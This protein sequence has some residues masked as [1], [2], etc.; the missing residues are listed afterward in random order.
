MSS[1][2]PPRTGSTFANLRQLRGGEEFSD[3][4]LH[5]MNG[6]ITATG[7]TFT[8][9]AGNPAASGDFA[10]LTLP[11]LRQLAD[12]EFM[13]NLQVVATGAWNP[14]VGVPAATILGPGPVSITLPA[15]PAATVSGAALALVLKPALKGE[16]LA[17]ASFPELL[18]LLG[19]DCLRNDLADGT[20]S[21]L[22]FR[23]RYAAT[24]LLVDVV[25]DL[26]SAIVQPLKYKLDVPRPRTFWTPPF[27]PVITQP[28]H[29]SYP[30][31]HATVAHTLA[32]VMT[33]V[34]G[35]PAPPATNALHALADH[36]ALRREDAGVHTSVDSS[37]G[38]TLG[39]ALGGFM[40][41]AAGGTGF[42]VWSAILARARTEL[43]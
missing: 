16:M 39:T 3:L 40:L 23:E 7:A 27:T 21:D 28:R 10:K 42:P 17:E 2:T 31:G 43:V 33:S 41:A 9:S 25:V 35:M 34:L 1:A 38:K 14:A 37:V 6:V 8:R 29:A 13:N 24:M 36:V 30:S 15:V 19:I 12:A 22:A 5:T 4:A 18:F 26:V 32:A 20:L 11:L